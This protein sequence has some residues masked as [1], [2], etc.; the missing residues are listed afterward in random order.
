MPTPAQSPQTAS[1]S[2]FSYNYVGL[3]TYSSASRP[4]HLPAVL[5]QS[6]FQ[7]RRSVPHQLQF[8][9]LSPELMAHN[10]PPKCTWHIRGTTRNGNRQSMGTVTALLWCWGLNL[11]GLMA[12]RRVQ[13]SLRRPAKATS[14][15]CC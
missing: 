2:F 15:S 14:R 8:H 3:E 12:L 6:C 10:Q 4:Q 13:T 11:V 1:K 9:Q 7:S 5:S